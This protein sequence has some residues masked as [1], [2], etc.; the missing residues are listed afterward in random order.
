MYVFLT[1][2]FSGLIIENNNKIAIYTCLGL[3]SLFLELLELRLYLN[4]KF[5]SYGDEVDIYDFDSKLEWGT[6]F[7]ITWKY[8]LAPYIR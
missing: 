2:Y 6:I 7:E 4:S 3:C 5:A 8:A 1:F